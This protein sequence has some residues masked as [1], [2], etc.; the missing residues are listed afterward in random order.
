M[1]N[2]EELY[3]FRALGQAIKAARLKQ[4][5][6]RDEAAGKIHIDPRYLTNIEN[7][8][9]HPSLQIFYKLVTLFD[10]SV[11]QFFYPD[12]APNKSTRR[13]QLDNILDAF[14]DNDMIIMEATADGIKRAKEETEM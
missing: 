11:D 10:I 13:R 9:Q 7:K 3:D 14:H 1:R 2:K 6:T 5:M 8:G 12:T 4:G